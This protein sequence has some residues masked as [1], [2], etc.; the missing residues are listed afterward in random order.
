MT[1][2]KGK[3]VTQ[4]ASPKKT[5]RSKIADHL[6]SLGF[7]NRLAMYIIFLLTAGLAGGFYLACESIAYSYTGALACYTVVFTP[8]GT[9][10]SVVLSKI[11]HKSEVENS[12]ANGEGI[13]YAQAKAAGFAQDGGSANSP[14]I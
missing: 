4:D 9:A 8:I 10:C 11:V 2:S 13:K 6:K 14:S 5:L 1:L 3:R 12:G 7:T